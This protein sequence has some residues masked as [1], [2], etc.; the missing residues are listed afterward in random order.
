MERA[1]LVLD[2]DRLARRAIVSAIRYGGFDVETAREARDAIRLL[3]RR[4]C[5]GLIA[6][7]DAEDDAAQAVADLRALTDAPII[8]VSARDDR[9]H[10][11][12]LLDAGADD[13]MTR[14][15]DPEELLA[16]LRAVLRRVTRLE[17]ERPIVTDDFT[18]Y[19]R[20]RRLVLV[21]GTE[22]GLSPTEWRL[23][24]VLADHAGHLV[25]REELLTA[26]W[27]SG[28]VGKTQYLRVHMAS[29][30][31]KI[32][33]DPSR[34]RYFLTIAGLGLKFMPAATVN[35]AFGG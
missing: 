9:E 16:R 4:H 26:V 6:D 11:V 15:F 19:V 1:V 25:T 35:E 22:P 12:E 8:V 31:H 30:R 3:R 34:P 23:I 18:M 20:D 27:G 2:P 14:P 5:L 17:A 29:I 28:A 24:E 13:Y 21:D 10:K 32:E 7:P 33:P